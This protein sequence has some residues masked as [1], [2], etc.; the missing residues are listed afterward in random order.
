LQFGNDIKTMSEIDQT[1]RRSFFD[2]SPRELRINSRFIEFKDTDLKST[3]PTRIMQEDISDFCFGYKPIRGVYF[4]VGLQFEFRIRDIHQ[5]TIKI[6]FMYYYRI[7]KAKLQKLYHD[8]LNALWSFYFNPQAA[9]FIEAFREGKIIRIGEVGLTV[10]GVH[11]E[12]KSFIIPWE[13]VGSKIYWNNFTIYSKS[14]L[15]NV[16]RSFYFLDDWNT[17]VLATLL[18]ELPKFRD[19]VLHD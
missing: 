8:I 12:D 16:S 9:K 10:K 4:Y 19:P 17:L 7:R 3:P 11:F 5:K 14:N 15:Q 1:I 13:D 2:R 6:S 18:Q